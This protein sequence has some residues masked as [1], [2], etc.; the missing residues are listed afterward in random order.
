MPDVKLLFIMRD[1]VERAWSHAR[2]D[3]PQF[4]NKPVE[5]AEID[6][7][8]EF[9]AQV[10]PPWVLKPRSQAGSMGIKKI[11]SEG[12]LWRRLE[13]QRLVGLEL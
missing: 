3:F 8:R 11:Y 7:L 4:R 13:E 5:E 12:E 9:M 6:E 10:E 1:P 2:K